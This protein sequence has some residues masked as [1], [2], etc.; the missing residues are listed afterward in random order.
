MH[1]KYSPVNSA[2]SL[3]KKI[4]CDLFYLFANLMELEP[5][6]LTCA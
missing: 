2:N 3:S 6:S 5:M 1:L 4:D